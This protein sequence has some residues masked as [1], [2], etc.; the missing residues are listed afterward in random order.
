[1]ALG[2]T[3]SD[4]DPAHRRDGAGLLLIGAAILTAAGVWWQLDGRSGRLRSLRSS[5][6]ASVASRGCVPLL[7]VAAGVRLLRHPSKSGPTGRIV[8]GWT[9]LLMGVAGGL[10]VLAGTPQ[11]TDGAEAMR[12]GGGWLGYLLA[13]PLTSA[14][15]AVVAFPLLASAGRVRGA[16]GD[17]HSGPRRCPRASETI[18]DRLLLR[19]NPETPDVIDLTGPELEPLKRNRPRRRVGV[20]ADDAVERP[21]DTPLVAARRRVRRSGRPSIRSARSV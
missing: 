19:P 13:A 15:T 1:M 20:A 18:L 6:V 2:R 21:F 12:H 14:V 16:G 8:I 3:R 9:A 17:R 5:R 11:A 4:L 10:H 7:L